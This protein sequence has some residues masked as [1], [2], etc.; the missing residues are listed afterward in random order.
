[1]PRQVRF[2]HY[3]PVDVL[4]VDEVDKP[5]P[6]DDQVLVAVRAAGINPF[7]AKLHSGF[8]ES[9]FSVSFPAPQGT[10][11]AGVVEAVGPGVTEFAPGDEILGS[12]GKR[13]AQADYALVPQ[14]TALKRPPSVSWEVAGGFWT[15]ACAASALV[16]AAGVGAGDNVLVSGSGGVG[17]TA[18]QLARLKGANVICVT[19][20]DAH[21]WLRSFGVIPLAFGDGVKERITAALAG[22]ALNAVMD[23]AGHGYVQLGIELGVAPDR[24]DTIV[25]FSAAEQ[26]GAKTDGA[27][28]A[29]KPE[30][31]EVLELVAAGK[32]DLPVHASYPLDQVRE[33]YTELEQ[34]H[35]QGKIVIVP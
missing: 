5:V 18:C 7:D 22:A 34:R 15:V 6:A 19:A 11:V 23:T 16:R 26:V 24:I 10:D 29:G 4:Q 12:T 2:D 27:D 9:S 1:M 3:G 21:D 8:F 31:A 17:G 13:G 32:L 35:P 20:E 25:D 28:A 33:A 14:K 30:A